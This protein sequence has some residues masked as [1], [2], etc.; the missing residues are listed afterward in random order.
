MLAISKTFSLV[1]CALGGCLILGCQS[2]PTLTAK[3]S[4][5]QIVH[6]KKIWDHAGHNA[7]TDLI[8]FNDQWFCTFREATSHLAGD[9]KI[10]VIISRDGD[11]W[12]SA[13][14]LTEAGVDFRDPKLSITADHRL[15]LVL[16]GSV[17]KG[18][19]VTDRQP[20]VA[21][22]QDGHEW[23][24][25]QR[26]LNTNDWLWRVTWNNGHAYGV[27][28]RSPAKNDRGDR[29]WAARFVESGDGVDFHT[30][31]GFEIPDRPN[32]ATAR[33]LKNG[34]CVVLIRREAGDRAAWIG[35][36]SPPFKDWKWKSAGMFIGGPDFIVLNDGAMVAGGR[37]LNPPPTGARTFIGRMTLESV[38]PELI[39]PSG[40]DC[41]YPG[42]VWRDG[43]LWVSY[44][45]S[46]EG[47]AEIYFAKIKL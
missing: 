25:P 16:N 29:H 15:M 17:H 39:L 40:G 31:A 18:A 45:S 20:R 27:V 9:G 7:F 12:E 4:A 47:K 37:Q 32:E 30:V 5:P 23:T 36:S 1:A 24:P 35:V 28:Y 21:F 26:V 19:V 13:A 6:V 46:H 22:S 38:T 2:V 41:S 3:T 11:K 33:F 43:F 14:L 8:R 44:Y 34:D 42:L 10:R